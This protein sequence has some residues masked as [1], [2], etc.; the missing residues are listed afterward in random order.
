MS[1]LETLFEGLESGMD[2]FPS[3]ATD[4]LSM[5]RREFGHETSKNPN[6]FLNKQRLMSTRTHISFSNVRLEVSTDY[7]SSQNVGNTN[8]NEADYGQYNPPRKA[9]V[10]PFS[11]TY[12]NSIDPNP[13]IQ[14]VFPPKA[15][16]LDPYSRPYYCPWNNTSIETSFIG[17]KD[18]IVECSMLDVIRIIHTYDVMSARFLQSDVVAWLYPRR[19]QSDGTITS[20]VLNQPARTFV[21]KVINCEV[22]IVES[23]QSEMNTKASKPLV[24]SPKKYVKEGAPLIALPV[25]YTHLTLPTI[26]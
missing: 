8:S 9:L 15:T 5:I 16:M 6:A 19:Q 14:Q 18:L 20:V 25:S 1:F 2:S 11:I 23:A 17:V 13:S 21:C 22:K 4:L 3:C 24:S 12:Y 10:R 7:F 26:A